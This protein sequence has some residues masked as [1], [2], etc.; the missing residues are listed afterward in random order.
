[1]PLCCDNQLQASKD[2]TWQPKNLSGVAMFAWDDAGLTLTCTVEDDVLA[3]QAFASESADA[4]GELTGDVLALSIFPRLNPDGSVASDQLRWYLSL[5]APGGGSG[6]T[7]LFRPAKYAGGLK[8]GQ[9]ARDSSV[10]RVNFRREGTRT[11]YDLAI[12]WGEL[13]GFTPAKG[14][15]FGCNLVLVDGDGAAERGEMVWGAQPGDS[16]AG[17]GRVT[18]VP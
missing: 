17:C 8:A 2:Y 4:G 13:P 3:P 18:L 5:A 1:M 14:A 7:T 11:I 6:A 10:Y 15:R 16:S 12:P 9:L